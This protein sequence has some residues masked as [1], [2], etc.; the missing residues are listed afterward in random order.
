MHLPVAVPLPDRYKTV[1]SHGKHADGGNTD[2]KIALGLVGAVVVALLGL[3][4]WMGALSGVDVVEA[5]MGPYQFVYVQEASADASRIGELSTALAARLDAAGIT[6]HKPAQVYFPAGG[7]QNQI[8]FVVDRQVGPEVLGTET[9]FRLVHAQRYMVVKFPFRNRL[10]FVAG[11]FR[12]EPA[13]RKWQKEHKYA[14]TG[15]MVILEGDTIVY[16]EPIV[17][18]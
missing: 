4:G 1:E 13:L 5:E 7:A 12:V 10:S 14:E 16:L 11:Y 15:A 2:V 8:G 17:P 3:L 9:Y 18:A 6:Q